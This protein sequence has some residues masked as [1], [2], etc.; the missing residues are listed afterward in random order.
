MIVDSMKGGMLCSV[1]HSG[2]RDSS[3]R[4]RLPAPGLLGPLGATLAPC[5][6][7]AP[8]ELSRDVTV[9]RMGLMFALRLLLWW[10]VALLRRLTGVNMLAKEEKEALLFF[11]MWLNFGIWGAI[12]AL[13]WGTL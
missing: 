12:A 3:G 9:P 8:A 6:G 1:Y 11:F 2:P 7:P 4:P 13:V 5:S 10:C